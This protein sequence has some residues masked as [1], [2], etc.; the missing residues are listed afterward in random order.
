[1]KNIVIFGDSYSTFSGYVPEGY[2]VYYKPEGRKETDVTRV[3]QTWWHRL[4][5]DMGLEIVRNDSWSGTTICHTGYDG[6]DYS[7]ISFVARLDRLAAEGFFSQ[8]EIDT[9]LVF[10][11]TNDSW[12]D[13]PLGELKEHGQTREDLF[14][15]LPAIGYMG[16]RLRE[17]LPKARILFIINTELK[18][19]IGEAIRTTAARCG[20]EC[21]ALCDVDKMCGHPTVRG[22]GEIF[23]QVK[24]AL[25]QG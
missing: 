4:T 11:G 24:Q 16:T 5:P 18:S 8:N 17:L 9:V 3:E 19:E 20:A 7:K 12:A 6:D 14:C 2:D 15:V 10:G 23:E 22:M 1:M 13:S 21:V 25:L